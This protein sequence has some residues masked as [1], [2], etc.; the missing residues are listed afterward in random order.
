MPL[1]LFALALGAFAIGT[2]EF[3]IMGLLPEVAADLGVPIPTAG[4][5][6]SAYALGVVVGAPLLT[7]LSTRLPRKTA[8]LLFMGVFLLGNLLTVFAPSHETVLVSRFLA[9]VPHGAYLGVAA[10]VAA[11]L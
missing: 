9:G 1:A 8:L 11:H 2:T 4:H 3:V 7:A 10:L 5:L 6:I